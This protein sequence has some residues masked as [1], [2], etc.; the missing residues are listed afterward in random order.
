MVVDDFL[1][2][3]AIKERCTLQRQSDAFSEEKTKTNLLQQLEINRAF[4]FYFAACFAA[5]DFAAAI[6]G[7]KRTALTGFA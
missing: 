3:E 2:C 4:F 1:C 6:D 7:K 5:R